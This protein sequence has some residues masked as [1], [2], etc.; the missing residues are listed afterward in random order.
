MTWLFIFK[1]SAKSQDLST[2][3]QNSTESKCIYSSPQYGLRIQFPA[4]N[5][6]QEEMITQV[7]MFQLREV[8]KDKVTW[9]QQRCE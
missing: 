8:I 9:G 6:F 7:Q 1:R 5:P 3:A 4:T 2:Q